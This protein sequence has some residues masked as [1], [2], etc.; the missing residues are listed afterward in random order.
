MSITSKDMLD[1]LY[2]KKL[3]Q[4]Y[5]DED[6]RIGYPLKRYLESLIDGGYYGSI[7]DIEKLMTLVDPLSIPEEF[8]QYL[9]ESFGLSYFPDIEATYQ[10]KF[11]LNIGEIVKRRGTFSCVKYLAR[12]LTGFDVELSY[13]EGVHNG[14]DGNYLFI[15][16]LA[17]DL[18]QL[19]NIDISM[20]VI[21]KY[22]SGQIPYYIR[23]VLSYQVGTQFINSK[24]YSQSAVCS[25]KFYSINHKKKE[26]K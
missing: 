8:L 13:F 15:N 7:K 3:P 24:S 22:V 19:K 11:L 1:L 5:R 10:R 4:V 2:N 14:V 20:E 18:E 9:C 17:K 25:Y 26:V 16:L 21:S 12:A 23:P 6:K